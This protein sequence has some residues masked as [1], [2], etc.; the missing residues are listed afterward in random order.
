MTAT[1]NNAR[2]QRVQIGGR[3]MLLS[4]AEIAAFEQRFAQVIADEASQAASSSTTPTESSEV[5]DIPTFAGTDAEI[6]A[7]SKPAA[8]KPTKGTPGTTNQRLMIAISGLAVTLV[9]IAVSMLNGG[10]QPPRQNPLAVATLAPTTAAAAAATAAP[11]ATTA[12]H[13]STVVAYFDY[14]NPESSTEITTTGILRV[15][16]QADD[17][18]LVALSG[19]RPSVWLKL[20]DVPAGLASADPLP[21]L[22]P[23]PTSPPAPTRQ[24]VAPGG[25]GSGA[26]TPSQCVSME[27][28][29][30]TTERDVTRPN[31]NGTTDYLGHVVGRSCYSQAEADANADKEEQLLIQRHAAEVRPTMP[32]T[33]TEMPYTLPS[34]TPA[35]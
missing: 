30:F 22:A 3:S 6:L 20:A 4:E 16:G 8:D 9:I 31:T 34:V 10:G 17:W 35:R 24:P 7:A 11:T 29:R 23:R 26:G 1:T 27:D 2:M 28:I 15:T 18:R 33:A 12:A 25:S 19:G 5:A 21:D 13:E 32:P 14:A